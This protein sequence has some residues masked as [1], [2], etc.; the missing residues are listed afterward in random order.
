[1][2]TFIPNVYDYCSF[3]GLSQQLLPSDLVQTSLSRAWR[4][5]ISFPQETWACVSRSSYCCTHFASCFSSIS[6]FLSIEASRASERGRDT[7]LPSIVSSLRF[8]PVSACAVCDTD[9]LQSDRSTNTVKKRNLQRKSFL[10]F[11]DFCWSVLRL[12]ATLHHLC[13]FFT[14]NPSWH[15]VLIEITLW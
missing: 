9:G 14:K 3:H 4:T 11:M 12:V 7:F 1:M 10:I 15:T 8:L 2:C 13:P 6:H 5:N